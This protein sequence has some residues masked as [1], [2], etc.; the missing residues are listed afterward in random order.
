MKLGLQIK[1]ERNEPCFRHERAGG[2]GSFLYGNQV[3]KG[4]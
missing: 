4:L 2:L 1:G 3:K